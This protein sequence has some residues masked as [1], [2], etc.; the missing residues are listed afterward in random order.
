MIKGD[1]AFGFS[2]RSGDSIVV[3][4]KGKEV[5]ISGGIANPAIYELLEKEGLQEALNYA[6]NLLQ[7]ASNEIKIER[8]GDKG[9]K[10][11][12]KVTLPSSRNFALQNG[13]D[14]K[15]NNYTPISNPIHTVELTGEVNNPGIYTVKGQPYQT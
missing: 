3:N 10:Q 9:S 2:L 15:V 14:I 6:G 8:S 7:G 5:S 1:L 13:D 12:Y 11:K 4:P